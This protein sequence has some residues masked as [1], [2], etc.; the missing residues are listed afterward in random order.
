MAYSTPPWTAYRLYRNFSTIVKKTRN[1][2]VTKISLL[3]ILSCGR[4]ALFNSPYRIKKCYCSTS[5]G[6]LLV[7]LIPVRSHQSFRAAFQNVVILHYSSAW[8]LS[9][10]CRS[11]RG[12]SI[13]SS[14]SSVMTI[15]RSRLA[16][17]QYESALIEQQPCRTSHPWYCLYSMILKPST[18]VFNRYLCCSISQPFCPVPLFHAKKKEE[19]VFMVVVELR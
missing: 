16:L 19:A 8:V 14:Y 17:V 15:C 2:V 3:S 4:V 6:C 1:R 13:M 5:L 10:C 11:T 18:L 7:L 12:E 9:W